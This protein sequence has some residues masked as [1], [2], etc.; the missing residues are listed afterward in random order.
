MEEFREMRDA[1]GMADTAKAA[2][3]AE[4]VVDWWNWI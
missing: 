4:E 3:N 2:G 1:D